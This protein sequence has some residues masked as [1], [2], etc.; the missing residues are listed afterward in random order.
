MYTKIEIEQLCAEYNTVL[1][2][3]DST[4]DK[5][6]RETKVTI[7]CCALDCEE[8][9]T[10][11]ARNLSMNKN[12]GCKVHCGKFKGEKIKKTKGETNLAVATEKDTGK[13]YTY[14]QLCN[15]ECRPTLFNICLEL[16]ITQY[17]NV[18]KSE[19]INAIIERQ[20]E[21]DAFKGSEEKL[22]LRIKLF[23]L[24]GKH[25]FDEVT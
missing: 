17:H 4:K 8:S 24:E 2:S 15:M 14:E 21:L 16:K 10:K 3:I 19:V 23:E 7:Q 18:P 13:R 11:T 5:F 1:I 9:V 12:F 25:K 20:N 22:N 6:S